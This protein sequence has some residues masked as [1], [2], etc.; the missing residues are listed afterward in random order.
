[1][2]YLVYAGIAGAAT[3]LSGLLP[4]HPRV[5]FNLRYVVGFASGIVIGTALFEMIPAANPAGNW[6]IIGLGFFSFYL[7]E[8]AVTIHTCGEKECRIERIGL[9]ALL[10]ITLD[11]LVD[12]VAI[13]VG[14]F[15]NPLLGLFIALAVVVHEVPQGLTTTVVM[16]S[17]GY[18]SVKILTVLGVAAM[19]YP[20]GASLSVLLPEEVYGLI[21]AFV[22][23]EFLYIGA[24]E[25]LP[26][27]HRVLNVQVVLMVILGVAVIALLELAS[28]L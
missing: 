23:G 5:K 20:A 22:A 2:L 17:E 28:G 6:L 25:L 9:P 11:N 10:G 12:G 16:K 27:A 1:M 19:L 8:M 7:I 18:S 26:E 3:I 24:G 4:L 14:F 21:I 15:T 13:A